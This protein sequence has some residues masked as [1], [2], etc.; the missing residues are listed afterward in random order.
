[1]GRKRKNVDNSNVY[2]VE[3]I[4][5]K[6]DDGGVVKYLVKWLDY[7][8]DQNTWEPE[9]NFK[10]CPE[11]IEAYEKQLENPEQPAGK[12]FIYLSFLRLYLSLSILFHRKSS[13]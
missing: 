6:K 11:V 13:T 12:I 5:D 2:I 9:R 10:N 8:S 1:M 3:K 4:L 7:S